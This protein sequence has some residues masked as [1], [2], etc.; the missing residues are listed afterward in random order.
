MLRIVLRL[1]LGLV[2]LEESED[3]TMMF[4]LLMGFCFLVVVL[5]LF[6]EFLLVL[7]VLFLEFLLVLGFCFSPIVRFFFGI[8]LRKF[9]ARICCSAGG[10]ST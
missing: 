8:L 3:S 5:V 7:L 6:L 1:V 10:P 4:L 9:M 2:V